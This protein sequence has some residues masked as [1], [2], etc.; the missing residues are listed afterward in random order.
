MIDTPTIGV[1]GS[2]RLG[3]AL[4]RLLLGAGYEVRIANSRGPESLE[5]LLSVLLPGAI[6]TTVDE[7]LLKSDVIILA[8]PAGNYRMLAA[9]LFTGKIVIDAMNYWAPTEG[10]IDEFVSV[11]PFLLAVFQDYFKS[12]KAVKSLNHIAYNELEE[13]SR[14]TGDTT[15]RAVLMTG[16]DIPAK[17]VVGKIIDDI[18]FDAVDFGS[19]AD[20]VTYQPDTSLF[21]TQVS[22]SDVKSTVSVRS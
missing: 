9:D 7:A 13:H 5:L 15:R 10:V 12:A 6:A 14:T 2:G 21:N 8:L 11:N 20:G 16:D 3:T 19:L 17:Q 22:M 1:I 18:G 4:T